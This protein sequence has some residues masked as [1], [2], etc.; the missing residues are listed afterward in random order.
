ME[1]NTTF[2][3]LEHTIVYKVMGY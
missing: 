3:K 1:F 2:S